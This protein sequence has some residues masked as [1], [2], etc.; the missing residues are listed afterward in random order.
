MAF[1]SRS[2][3]R[4]R[5]LRALRKAATGRMHR[6]PNVAE[7]RLYGDRDGIS[8]TQTPSVDSFS[9]LP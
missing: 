8:G 7:H 4:D 6:S 9:E 1:Q 3:P 2:A 5:D